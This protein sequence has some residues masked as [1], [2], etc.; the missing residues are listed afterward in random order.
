MVIMEYCLQKM[1]WTKVCC[2]Y[3]SHVLLFSRSILHMQHC[4]LHVAS[5]FQ[6]LFSSHRLNLNISIELKSVIDQLH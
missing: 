2:C 4:P 5:P 3:S 1:F 6:I